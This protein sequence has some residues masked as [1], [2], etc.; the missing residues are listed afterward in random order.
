MQETVEINVAS[1]PTVKHSGKTDVGIQRD[2]NEDFLLVDETIGLFVVCDGM[3]GHAA[4]EVASEATAKAVVERI[5]ASSDSLSTFNQTP[6]KANREQV[7]ALLEDAIEYAN[8]K[9]FQLAQEDQTRHGMG[10]TIVLVLVCRHGAF[11]AH[12][13]DSRIYLHRKNEVHQVTEDHSLVNTLVQKGVLSREDAENHPNANVITRAVGVQEYVEAEVRFLDTEINDRF[14]ICSDGLSDYT[15]KD[16]LHTFS[17]RT[18]VAD[19]PEKLIKFANARGG[20]DNITAVVVQVGEDETASPAPDVT[21]TKKINVLKR[22][23]LFQNLDFN[24]ISLLLQVIRVTKYANN[25]VVVREGEEGDDMYVLLGGEAEVSVNGK[26]VANL[27]AGGHFGEMGLIDKAPRS[28][29]VTTT[30]NAVMLV[31]KRPELFA[32]LR[33]YPDLG[34]KLFWSLLKKM[35]T[36]LRQSESLIHDVVNAEK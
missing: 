13:G 22:V 32:L 8:R 7:T 3:G 19:L 29:T 16:D 24:Q 23:P 15:S 9:V 21:A 34:M 26:L 20:K 11:I 25:E 4:G 14:I 27:K 36:R 31:L 6:Q 1:A 12:V 33:R 10:T 28:A 2:H 17:T 35:N 30:S 5:Q 18:D